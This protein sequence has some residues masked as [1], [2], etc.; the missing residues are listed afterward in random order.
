[1]FQGTLIWVFVPNGTPLTLEYIMQARASGLGDT[2]IGISSINDPFV[3]STDPVQM[4][5]PMTLTVTD[6]AA[7]VPEPESWLLCLAGLAI[8]VW[9]KRFGGAFRDQCVHDFFWY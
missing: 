8:L 3:L 2:N 1:L 5:D 4:F 7:D 9:S 6:V